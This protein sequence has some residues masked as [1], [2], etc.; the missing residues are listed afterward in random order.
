M[1]PQDRY[2][3]HG[4]LDNPAH[5]WKNGPGGV[6][7]SRP[8]VG[9]GWHFPSFPHGY[10][11]IWH[12][13]THLQLG[14]NLPGTGWLLETADFERQNIDLYSD[15]HSKNWLSFVFDT[16]LGL[17]A[18]AIFFLAEAFSDDGDALGCLVQL[19]NNGKQTQK[20]SLLAALDYERNLGQ[21]LDWT[22]GLYARPNETGVTVA[23]FQEG[24][25]FH[26]RST[27]FSAQTWLDAAS[28]SDLIG[29]LEDKNPR[30]F[31]G[32]SRFTSLDRVY[33]EGD[34]VTRKVAAQQYNFE[35]E[36]GAEKTYLLV[37]TRDVSEFRA[38]RRA[39]RLMEDEGGALYQAMAQGRQ[40]DAAFWEE[41]PRLSGDWPEHVRRGL[42]YD[43]ET[44]RMMVREPAGIYKHS[45]DAMQLQVPRTVLAEAALDMLILSYADP[46]AAKEVLLGTFADAPESNVPCSREDGSYNMVA[47]DGSP[48]GTAPEWCFPFHCIELVYRRT[49]DK[50]WLAELFPYLEA[51]IRF[52]QI[53]RTDKQGRPFYKCSWEAGQ[54]NSARFAITDDPSGGGALGE[55]LWPVD[56]QAAMT[57][58]CWL[59]AS[60][61]TELG[62]EENRIDRWNLLAGRHFE[63]MQQMWRPGS[64]WFHDFDRRS[65]FTNVLD[66]MQLAPLLGRAVTPE[67]IAALQS[68]L[69]NPPLHGQVFHPLMWPSITFCLVEACSESGR[70][71]LAAKH[72]WQALDAFYRWA[73]SHP[74][75][76]AP[77]QG[78]LPGVGREYWP[79]VGQPLAVPPRGGGGAE[80]YGWGCLG[81]Y[82][83]LRYVVGL[84]E[85]RPASESQAAF[86]L[87][88]NLPA[89]L[90]VPGK[91]YRVQG[92]PCQQL[93]LDLSLA[94]RPDSQIE[95]TLTAWD[96][97]PGGSNFLETFLLENGQAQ[98]V[99]LNRAEGLKRE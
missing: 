44:L 94:V 39:F 83:L 99:R 48:C 91:V 12:Y 73:D 40:S 32:V 43:L 60:W 74:A 58:S 15:Y 78:G 1:F 93:K 67:Q 52:W 72:G 14:F 16:D 63:L 53:E 76:V 88:P 36:P 68:K 90:L 56:L 64:S 31:P 49:L 22:S 27:D 54:D 86:A 82:L 38:I 4:Y 96:N 19:K 11:Y 9:M 85:E 37:M 21:G 13:A 97:R 10:N 23:G 51:Y 87:R 57:Q 42:V 2:T 47:V 30:R 59:L 26:L 5:A 33:K 66:T 77:D 7:R 98:L 55:H 95:L 8:G 62:L 75:S 3:P 6:L 28:F 17:K 71:D 45:W 61:A 70:Q 34:N 20:G 92:I 18:R 35:L 50:A 65:G 29:T 79:Q 89:A 41:A 69:E 80:V 81:S 24:T 46:V 84:Q 25:A